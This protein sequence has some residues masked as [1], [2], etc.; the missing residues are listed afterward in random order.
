MEK[1]SQYWR[2]NCYMY[3]QEHNLCF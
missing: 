3:A 2:Y 1:I